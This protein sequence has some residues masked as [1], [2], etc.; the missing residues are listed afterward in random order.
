MAALRLDSDFARQVSPPIV[1]GV[2][3]GQR[4]DPTTIVVVEAF[5]IERPGLRPEYRFEARHMERLAIGTP[6]PAVGMRIAEVVTTLEDRPVALHL[7]PRKLTLVVDATGVGRPVVDILRDALH[8]SRCKLT[9]ATFTHGDRLDT[10][11]RLE[12]R[13]GKAFLVSRLQAL[14]QTQRIKL[15]A[16]H[17]EAQA[18]AKELVDYELKVDPDGQDKYGAFRVG[19]H[20][21]LV[22]ALGLAVLRDPP[23]PQI[24]AT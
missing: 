2:D 17:P 19:A 18:M 24:W 22:T 20:D 12:W 3:I 23:G 14:F 1:V 21:D 10:T 16:N 4:V 5:K 6:Y 9:P 11:S 8:G 15:P 7:Q 13:V